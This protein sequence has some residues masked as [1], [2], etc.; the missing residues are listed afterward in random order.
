MYAVLHLPRFRLQAVLRHEPESWTSPIALMDPGSV[1]PRTVELTSA[2]REA[3]VEE[4]MTAPQAMSRCGEVRLR[5]RSLRA[6]EEAEL[7]LIQVAHGFSPNL[8]WTGPG[9]IT[10]ELRGLVEL[11]ADPG[12]DRLKAWANRWCQA[13]AALGL[14]GRI[15]LGPTPGV[16]RHAAMVGGT[17]PVRVV[18]AGEAEG[19]IA[20]LPVT[21]LDPTPHVARQLAQWGIR[22]VGE[23]RALGQ[24]ELAERLGLEAFALW[25]SASAT[26][27]RPLRMARLAEEFTE[28]RDLESPV[29]TLE[30]LLFLL[31]RFVESLEA[32]LQ[33]AGFAAGGLVLRLREESG[34]VLERRLRVPQ[35]TCRA[36]VLFR[37]LQTHL[38][39]VRTQDA[40]A[41]VHLEAEPARPVRH[42]FS[43]FDAALR[44]PHQFEETLARLSALVGSDRVGSPL[45]RD[46]HRPDSFRL[47][48]PDFENAPSVMGRRRPDLLRPIPVRRL[49]PALP[50][51]V[52]TRPDGLPPMSA[53]Q[54]TAWLDP[55]FRKPVVDP[56]KAR[57]PAASGDVEPVG[58]AIVLPFPGHSIP[59]PTAN[60]A[61]I[62]PEPG[63]PWNLRCAVAQGRVTVSIGPWVASGDWWD[64]GAWNRVEWD[65]SVR[66]AVPM[67]L[68][69]D[70]SDWRVEALM[71]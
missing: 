28:G 50:V 65:V 41:G 37:M 68:A 32:R 52:E 67:R 21:V 3:G 14:K 7:A 30:P 42:Q 4:G 49:R 66:D 24:G 39:G 5:H 13:T 16:A 64:S 57:D 53:E 34:A 36:D 63:R 54:V 1:T 27:T 45:R 69:W 71:D 25:A 48:P 33:A 29:E 23:M 10:L 26:A 18:M 47:V 8:E 12:A 11:G 9:W 55:L 6:E 20:L 43:L 70:G 38:E 22:T 46:G 61:S 35:P 40:I 59:E 58:D 2:A 17:D 31:R 62:G 60:S 56:V 44:D 19:F 51:E 15:G